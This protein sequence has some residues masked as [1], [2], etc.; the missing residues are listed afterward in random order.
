MLFSV[1]ATF[2]GWLDDK[3]WPCDTTLQDVINAIE[4]A[5]MDAEPSEPGDSEYAYLAEE[6]DDDQWSNLQDVMIC[7]VMNRETFTSFVED[8]GGWAS[9]IGTLGTLGGPLGLGIVPDI[10][11]EIESQALISSV[12][13]TPVPSNDT[14]EYTE[15]R[16]ERVRTAFL[17]VYGL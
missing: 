17:T 3:Y 8:I 4:A 10:V 11:I 9:D 6:S 13:V 7:G 5:G 15:E 12:R 2:T 16:W 1:V 14:V